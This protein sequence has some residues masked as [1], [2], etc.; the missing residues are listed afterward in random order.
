M[1]TEAKKCKVRRR[2]G[3]RKRAGGEV[4]MAE[5]NP[6]VAGID[7]G[8]T[9]NWVACAPRADG[10]PN[11]RTFGAHTEG[12]RALVDWVREEGVRSVAME[13][14]GVYWM[15]LYQVLVAAGIEVTLADART[16]GRVPGRKTDMLDCQW[17]RQL[18]AYGLLHASFVPDNET[19]ALRSLSRMRTRLLAQQADWT[20]RIQKQLDLMNVR[21]HRAVTDITGVTGMAI[22][23]AILAG[24]RDPQRLAALRDRRCAKD[25]AQIARE[26]DGDWRPE[27]VFNLGMALEQW[28]FAGQQVAR[29]DVRIG[30]QL[31][32][33]RLARTT[34]GKPTADPA[35]VPEHPDEAKR[36]LLVKRGGEPLRQALA[37]TF[38]RDLTLVPSIGPECALAVLA[39][40]GPDVIAAFPTEKQF[41]SWLRLAPNL[42]I[43]GGKPVR[44]KKP[45]PG[46]APPLARIL[47]TAAGTLRS[48]K[49]PMAAYYTRT[50]LRKGS[51]VAIFACARKLAQAVYRVLAH[52]DAYVLAGLEDARRHADARRRNRLAKAAAELGFSLVPAV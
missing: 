36:R 27:H 7:V 43:S 42:A 25:K 10:E 2:G 9:E 8:A 39:E 19:L 28:E 23:R 16:L 15:P 31:E 51:G 45:R 34:A 17:L 29:M 22:I 49:S 40:V 47:K 33:M 14:T 12:L 3:G 37:A 4:P 44:G 11:V 32:Q 20:R 26:L 24:E 21:V 35:S 30:E 48:A 18:H 6:H 13:S 46:G 1:D 50:A 41:V 38:D 52:G 5:V